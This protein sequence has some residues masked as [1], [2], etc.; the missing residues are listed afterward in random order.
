MV[1]PCVYLGSWIWICDPRGHHEEKNLN[2]V[3]IQSSCHRTQ[4]SVRRLWGCRLSNGQYAGY[5][6]SMDLI[7]AFEDPSENGAALGQRATT[8]TMTNMKITMD[9]WSC[10]TATMPKKA[11]VKTRRFETILFWRQ[12]T[13]VTM[14]LATYSLT[15]TATPMAAIAPRPVA[16]LIKL[17]CL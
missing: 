7:T 9:N 13:R 2:Q 17:C 1:L 11:I 16:A 3:W 8:A 14:E 15:Q 5:R 4:S 12:R 10:S 6:A